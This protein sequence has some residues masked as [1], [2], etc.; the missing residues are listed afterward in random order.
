M[1]IAKSIAPITMIIIAFRYE[2]RFSIASSF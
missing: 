1:G 2:N